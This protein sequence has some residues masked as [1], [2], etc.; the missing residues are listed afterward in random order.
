MLTLPSL[1]TNSRKIMV[2]EKIQMNTHKQFESAENFD[3]DQKTQ[4][5]Q[6]A[7]RSHTAGQLPR[8]YFE[9]GS[10]NQKKNITL[11]TVFTVEKL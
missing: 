7:W 2:T 5:C 3:N 10:F 9:I 8:N 11:S 4:C 6:P 1:E